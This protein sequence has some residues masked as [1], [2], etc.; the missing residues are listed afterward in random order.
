ME[1]RVEEK[2]KVVTPRSKY[3]YEMGTFLY[4]HIVKKK[5]EVVVELGTGRGFTTLCMGVALRENR[6]GHLTSYDYY[7]EPDWGTDI[8]FVQKEVDELELNEWITLEN[9]DAYMWLLEPPFERIDMLYLDIHNDGSVI[10]FFMANDFIKEQMENGM[11]LFFEG[12]ANGQ[13]EL[14]CDQRMQKRFSEMKHKH[15]ILFDR[16]T[17]LSVIWGAK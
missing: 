2:L 16:R 11:P 3:P 13:R 10:D 5:P 15:E 7:N 8:N 12:G 4:D 6:F 17:G 14:V 9:Q 1:Y